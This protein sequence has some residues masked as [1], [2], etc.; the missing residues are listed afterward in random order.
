MKCALMY[1]ALMV[2]VGM[3]SIAKLFPA[4][5]LSDGPPFAVSLAVS[6]ID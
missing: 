2:C 5:L 4:L 1:C 3:D 6:R